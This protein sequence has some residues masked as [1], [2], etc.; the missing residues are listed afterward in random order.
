M[1]SFPL[2]PVPGRCQHSHCNEKKNITVIP[3]PPH[4]VNIAPF[5]T[6]LAVL[7]ANRLL[8][9]A[10][11][12]YPSKIVVKRLNPRQMKVSWGFPAT[13]GANSRVK[14]FRVYYSLADY[15]KDPSRWQKKD[16]GPVFSTIVD[17][18]SVHA[19][20]VVRMSTLSEEGMEGSVECDMTGKVEA[21][22]MTVE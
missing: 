6:C 7:A 22:D 11:L 17:G 19:K 1:S 18:L 21:G 9:L 10:V 13:N 8:F 20:Y 4:G 15:P 16:V 2:D 3:F 12:Q 5:T 14:G